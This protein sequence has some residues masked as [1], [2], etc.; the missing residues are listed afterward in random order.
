LRSP[1]HVAYI[2]LRYGHTHLLTAGLISYKPPVSLERHEYIIKEEPKCI[3]SV[4]LA[5][6]AVRLNVS[7]AVIDTSV[8]RANQ[9]RKGNEAYICDPE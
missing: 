6:H 5:P 3:K 8:L 7:C 4:I 1:F 9:A 2:S